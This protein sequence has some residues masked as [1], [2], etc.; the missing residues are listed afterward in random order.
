MFGKLD[1][2]STETQKSLATTKNN[3]ITHIVLGAVNQFF[4]AVTNA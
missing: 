3:S 4:I 2:F 1:C